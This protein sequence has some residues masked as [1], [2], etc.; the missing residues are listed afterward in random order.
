VQLDAKA[1]IYD[2]V[3]GRVRL[4]PGSNSYTISGINFETATPLSYTPE[5]NEFGVG[6]SPG[7]I[8]TELVYVQGLTD[9]GVRAD[10][11]S[12]MVPKD[13]NPRTPTLVMGYL[14]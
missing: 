13:V 4:A 12:L 10:L 9:A 5:I 8:D 3:R 2:Y 11:D 14:Q 7:E 6:L 1:G